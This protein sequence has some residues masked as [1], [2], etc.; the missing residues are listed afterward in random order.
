VN[1]PERTL[2]TRRTLLQGAA[3]LA[4][5]GFAAPLLAQPPAANRAPPPPGT[6]LIMLGTRGGPGVSV[7]RSETASAVVVDGVPHLVDCGYGTMR[8]L[9]VSGIGY[10]AVSTM[11]LTHLHDDHTADIAALLSHQWTGSKTT[12]TNVYGPYATER[13]VKSA[14]EFFRPNVEIRM[15][16]EGRTQKPEEMFFGHDVDVVPE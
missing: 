14:I 8:A 9:V 12:P 7:D 1:E 11:F 15:V 5:L 2:T 10:Q 3:G 4:A 16:D 6:R 13:T